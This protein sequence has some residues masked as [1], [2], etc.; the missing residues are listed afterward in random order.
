[1]RL[2]PLSRREVLWAPLVLAALL[3]IYL[4]GVGNPLVFDDQLL[5]DGTIFR[6]FGSLFV[7]RARSLSYGTFVWIQAI[8]GE[9]WWKQRLFNLALHVAVVAALWGFYREILR[10]V[11]PVD[12]EALESSPAL[13]VAIGFFALNPVAVYA[14]AYLIQRSILMATLFVVLALWLF[15]LATARRKH[16][17]YLA[18]L[19]CYGA[20]VMSKEH[21]VLAPLAAIPVFILVDRPPLRRLAFA[22]A[23]CLGVLGIVAAILLQRYGEVI[24]QPFD[25]YSNVYLAQLSAIAP[26]ADTN[27]FGLSI[28]NQAYL[29]FHYAVRWFLPLA[30]WMSINL[31]PPFPVS[32]ATFPHALGIP[33]YLATLGAGLFLVWRFRD[34]RSLAGLGIAVPA[35]LFGT[36]FA[37]VW[38][39]DPFVLYRSYLWAIGL[40]ALVF[41]AIHGTPGRV[42]LVGGLLAA[43]LLV[44][45]S[46]DRIYSLSSVERAWT[47]AIAKLPNDPRSVGRWFPYLNRGA[48]RVDRGQYNLAMQDFDASSR[49]GDRGAGTFNRG[50]LYAANGE[51]E[52]AL[53]SFDVA[54]RDGYRLYS[55]PFQRGLT[56]SAIGRPEEAYRQFA[57]A[58][59]MQ[60]PSPTREIV[61]L[62]MGRTA[63][64]AGRLGEAEQSLKAL[65]DLQPANAD[66]RFYLAMTQVSRK[67][68]APALATLER[69]P[70]SPPSARA[71]YARALAHY[72]LQQREPAL[73]EID[74]AI[75][76]GPET[77]HLREWRSRIQAMK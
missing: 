46:L 3:V 73:A 21:A 28:L 71:H 61:L 65:L 31:R 69:M 24:G 12:G 64:Q 2:P 37:T 16:A 14:V 42:L 66:A 62:H 26:G 68:Y 5:A 70:A 52:N 51:H 55:L 44:W 41:I 49:L 76:I 29:F 38:V 32:W 45:Q 15:A 4:P 72:G 30:E 39:Q 23:A 47:D 63:L 56:L 59:S 53:L 19:A 9:G 22:A 48:A 74:A 67:E 60:P 27:A 54:E 18:A 40:P 10:H 20:A 58:W 50:A 75:R 8:A 17:L 36:E 11:E 57:K 34:W 6:D 7:E 25:E 43:V 77:P 1:M 35:L 33:A 13:G